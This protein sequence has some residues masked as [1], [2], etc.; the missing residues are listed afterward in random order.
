MRI[1]KFRIACLV[2]ICLLAVGLELRHLRVAPLPAPTR[3]DHLKHMPRPDFALLPETEA[4]AYAKL[5]GGDS[6]TKVQS[7]EPTVGDIEG[8]EANLSQIPAL[9]PNGEKPS[10]HIE[11][12]NQ[13]VRQYLAI[14]QDGNPRIF[15]NALC[16][17]D[18]GDSNKWRKHLELAADGGT[19]F[20]QAWYD[21]STQKF[22]NLSINGV[23]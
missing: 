4:T 16:S 3:N 11:D 2:L 14:V 23:G 13:Y 8:F 10:R 21:P 15:V 1:G 17:I 12:P 7:W 19:C 5:F 22:S 9:I 6:K 20:W 18:A